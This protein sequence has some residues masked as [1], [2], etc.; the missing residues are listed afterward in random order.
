VGGNVEPLGHG[1]WRQS[2]LAT[3]H[4]GAKYLQPDWL[5]QGSEALD[6]IFFFHPSSLVEPLQDAYASST[7]LSGSQP[8]PGWTSTFFGCRIDSTRSRGGLNRSGDALAM[9]PLPTNPQ[10]VS[11]AA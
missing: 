2:R 6:H 8:P 1:T 10:S 3:D 5:G 7:V 11:V 9:A 4:Q